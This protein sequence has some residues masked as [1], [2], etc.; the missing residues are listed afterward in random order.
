MCTSLFRNQIRAHVSNVCVYLWHKEIGIW[1]RYPIPMTVGVTEYIVSGCVIQ[2]IPWFRIQLF[3]AASSETDIHIA[4]G[5]RC[6]EFAY[7][8]LSPARDS[9]HWLGTIEIGEVL[10]GNWIRGEDIDN[11]ILIVRHETWVWFVQRYLV[12]VC[13]MVFLSRYCKFTEYTLAFPIGND[14]FHTF[15]F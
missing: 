4:A 14:H 3:G 8:L 10:I 5:D 1:G 6:A 15:C 11:A 12:C 7:S 9:E 2:M 13:F